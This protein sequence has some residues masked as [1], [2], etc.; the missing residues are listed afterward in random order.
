MRWLIGNE[1]IEKILNIN[2]FSNCGNPISIEVP[3]NIIYV[4]NWI[5]AKKYYTDPLW[6]ETTLE[7]RNVLTEFLHNKYINDY[8][9]WNKVADE[10]KNFLENSIKPQI[11]KFKDENN[12]DKI[13]VDCVMWDLL[14][15]IMEY[16]YQK[17]KNRPEFFGKL[18]NI[19]ESGNFPCG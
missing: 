11:V 8:I 12:L 14:G 4:S 1:I 2:W 3:L 7:A 19:Y 13:F 15:A 16:Y 6:E 10:A 5:E 17:C 18:L 9:N